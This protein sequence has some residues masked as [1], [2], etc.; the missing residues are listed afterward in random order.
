MN[1]RIL[2]LLLIS[3]VITGGCSG[4]T[5]EEV[6]VK[7]ETKRSRDVYTEIRIPVI[8]DFMPRLNF[9]PRSNVQTHVVLHFISHAAMNP[10]NP[11]IYEDI[12][13]I[14]VN[15]DVSP[16]YMIDREGKIYY[17]LPETR[18]ARHAGKGELP[19]YPEYKDD[20]NDYSIGIE[21]MA[22][23]TEAEM[24]TILS[25]D[26]YKK[27]PQE[28]IGYTEAQYQSLNLLLEDILARNKKIL[29]NREHIIGHDEYAPERKNDPGS[30]FDW[31][32][33]KLEG[34]S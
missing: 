30:L 33:L 32:K 6:V 12:R 23:G 11:Y 24:G 16:H 25:A 7:A 9:V 2:L 28:H 4:Q 5:H 18:A 14:F 21:L 19:G 27:I 22:I 26:V 10:E 17:L 31:S 13:E 29:R 20:L 8:Q 15:Y 1:G 3:L 34:D